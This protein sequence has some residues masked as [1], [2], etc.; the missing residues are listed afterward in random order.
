[1]RSRRKVQTRMK[2]V[3]VK[4]M[5]FDPSYQGSCIS[6]TYAVLEFEARFEFSAAKFS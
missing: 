2:E 3:L 6:L 1:M 4:V 5:A